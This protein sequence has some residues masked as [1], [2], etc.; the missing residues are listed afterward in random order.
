MNTKLDHLP[1]IKQQE[2]QEIV[3]IIIKAVNP[4]KIILFGSYASGKWIEDKYIS[5]GIFYEY[6]SDY[7]FL[8]VTAEDKEKEYILTERILANCG[9]RYKPPVNPIIHS[10]DFVNQGLEEGQYFFTEIV[11]AGILLFDTN[12]I[13]FAKPKEISHV[14]QRRLAQEYFD[15]WYDRANNF[16]RFS[17]MAFEDLKNRNKPLNDSAY[18]LHQTVER[19]F[20]CAI[21]TFNGYKPKTHNLDKL[22]R[23][24][25]PVCYEVANIFPYP[26]LD[27]NERHLFDLL[28]KAYIDARY[29]DNYLITEAELCQL[30]DRIQL[31][32]EVVREKCKER[33]LSLK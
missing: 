14:E 29:K 6:I 13:E 3:H 11:K 20:N 7:D 24:I 25:R 30:I 27:E 8:I 19:F 5:K 10:I 17:K 32:Q 15:T 21:L 18:L 28:K 26:T 1:E 4:A 33:I 9:D 23:Y 12:L 16:F 22:R 2:I 31:M